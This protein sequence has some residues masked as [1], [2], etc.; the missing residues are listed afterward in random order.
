MMERALSPVKPHAVRTVSSKSI[1][2]PTICSAALTWTS[3]R[4]A[5][6][7]RH[8][9]SI[10]GS[11]PR[12]NHVK[13]LAKKR[14]AI[15]PTQPVPSPKIRRTK[16]RHLHHAQLF[17]AGEATVDFKNRSFKNRRPMSRRTFE[18]TGRGDYIQA[19]P[20]KV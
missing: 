1:S 14:G 18:L 20:D 11:S 3:T 16:P 15:A 6:K 12:R 4:S 17:S 19:S 7:P 9:S 5:F 8:H 10:G 2:C 13:P